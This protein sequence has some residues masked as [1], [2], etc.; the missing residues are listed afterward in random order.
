MKEGLEKERGLMA[1]ARSK[2][3]RDINKYRR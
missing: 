1:K 3:N 2:K